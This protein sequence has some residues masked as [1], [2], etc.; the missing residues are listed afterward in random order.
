MSATQFFSTT[1]G[2]KWSKRRNDQLTTAVEKAL[3]NTPV[4][5]DKVKSHYSALHSY[6]HSRRFITHLRC[7]MNFTLD[8]IFILPTPINHT[9]G[10]HAF[11][12]ST[13]GNYLMP[14]AAV[15]AHIVSTVICLLG[16]LLGI[17]YTHLVVVF[18]VSVSSPASTERKVTL[19]L[20]LCCAAIGGAL[21]RSVSSRCVRGVSIFMLINIFALTEA[22][23]A[24]TYTFDVFTEYAY[25]LSCGLAISL[26]T[27]LVFFPQDS[28]VTLRKNVASTLNLTATGFKDVI[29][30]LFD[31][32]TEREVGDIAQTRRS[33]ATLRTTMYEVGLQLI[34]SR[35]DP[36][37]VSK[38]KKPL[39]DCVE[40]LAG[41]HSSLNTLKLR[42]SEGQFTNPWQD[43]TSKTQLRMDL[44]CLARKLAR[45]KEDVITATSFA[46]Q[47][48][49]KSAEL[50]DAAFDSY[51]TPSATLTFELASYTN[52]LTQLSRALL[53]HTA[54]CYGPMLEQ[55]FAEHAV[56]D[57]RAFCEGARRVA[58]VAMGVV[59]GLGKRR[60]VRRVWLPQK[61]REAGGAIREFCGADMGAV[62]DRWSKT[63]LR[64]GSAVSNASTVTVVEVEPFVPLPFRYWLSELL[65]KFRRSRHTQYTF[66]F[67]I[68]IAMIAAPA[69]I[70]DWRYWYHD[71]RGQWSAIGAII[72]ME[73]SHGMTTRN[74]LFSI[75]GA[76]VGSTLGYAVSKL[77]ELAQSYVLV[78]ALSA[79]CGLGLYYFILDPVWAKG[80]LV[81]AIAF[82]VVVGVSRTSADA[83]LSVEGIWARRAVALS[84]GLSIAF[85]VFTLVMP[86][87]ARHELLTTA[88]RTLDSLSQLFSVTAPQGDEDL[89]ISPA[90]VERISSVVKE[91]LAFSGTLLEATRYEPSLR[92]GFPREGWKRVLGKMR[93]V[94]ELRTKMDLDCP[95]Y[96]ERNQLLLAFSQDFL[97]LSHSLHTKQ[98][99]P[100][101]HQ[102]LVT[103][104]YNAYISALRE[105][106]QGCACRTAEIEVF[107]EIIDQISLLNRDVASILQEA[108]NPLSQ[109]CLPLHDKTPRMMSTVSTAVGTA[110]N[111]RRESRV[112]SSQDLMTLGRLSQVQSQSRQGSRATLASGDDEGYELQ[113]RSPMGS[114]CGSGSGSVQVSTPT[115]EV[116][117]RVKVSRPARTVS[118]DPSANKGQGM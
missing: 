83:G 53:K 105:G 33:Y 84:L 79:P 11:L 69:Y 101:N 8:I 7:A 21:T 89:S 34:F 95:S 43:S 86:Q 14:S 88:C 96:E 6:L 114:C 47:T 60:T 112:H 78:G 38:L 63:P 109:G 70:H 36:A 67:F 115:V 59:E 32:D 4:N 61:L 31:A 45:R 41:L 65:S 42:R 30:T 103:H 19:F 39:G 1:L 17:A 54:S 72:C 87:R 117:P 76:L 102:P 97:L 23:D 75:L 91:S 90:K 44:D 99:L 50:I 29:E 55:A 3:T 104:A 111:S 110:V 48:L 68:V 116:P 113:E 18:A 28:S 62:M 24:K 81:S 5:T 10:G 108:L 52:E 74:C 13:I 35:V 2:I 20:L 100:W 16:M 98:P 37:S 66:K 93:L 77:G 40:A 73:A 12:V 57:V 107:Q 51:P 9:L 46:S 49:K 56:E 25:P 22:I 80:S 94:Y 64:R 26:I 106:R 58:E 85:G 118:F 92:G 71:Y 27:S 82:S 15:G